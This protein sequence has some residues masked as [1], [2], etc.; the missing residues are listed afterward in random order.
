LRLVLREAQQDNVPFTVSPRY[1][2][3][4]IERWKIADLPVEPFSA[5]D[6]LFVSAQ[7][8]GCGDE[9]RVSTES[10][11]ASARNVDLAANAQ[12][13]CEDNRNRV[14]AG[15]SHHLPIDCDVSRLILGRELPKL[16]RATGIVHYHD[17]I[18]AAP[19]GNICLSGNRLWDSSDWTAQRK[20]IVVP[21]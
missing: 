14:I 17:C 21:D 1:P 6:T 20:V 5:L 8:M 12:G 13:R 19:A 11:H 3:Y 2:R 16:V 9:Q 10:Y 4:W 7:D 15:K 18:G